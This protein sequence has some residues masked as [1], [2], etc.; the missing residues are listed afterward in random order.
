MKEPPWYPCRSTF[1]SPELF[2]SDRKYGPS[3]GLNLRLIWSSRGERSVDWDTICGKLSSL[4]C[5]IL[6]FY[7]QVDVLLMLHVWMQIGLGWF[8]DLVVWVVVNCSNMVACE[9]C[10]E[11]WLFSCD[12]WVRREE[13]WLKLLQ[14]YY[15]CLLLLPASNQACCKHPRVMTTDDHKYQGRDGVQVCRPALSMLMMCIYLIYKLI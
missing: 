4:Q 6:L 13:Y 1:S 8:L 12:H 10:A 11:C 7:Q 14:C 3:L 15:L 9:Y 2:S 5:Y